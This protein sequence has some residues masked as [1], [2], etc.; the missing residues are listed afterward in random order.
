IVSITNQKGKHQNEGKS[1][2]GEMN[3]KIRRNNLF[4]VGGLLLMVLLL[5]GAM[6]PQ[7]GYLIT[8]PVTL[9]APVGG[10]QIK[11]WF[12]EDKALTCFD[13][14]GDYSVKSGEQIVARGSLEPF[15]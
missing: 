2:A 14:F 3:K 10:L 6:Y 11:C 13:A 5:T 8:V 9:G 4:W 15:D 12:G 7:R 1:E